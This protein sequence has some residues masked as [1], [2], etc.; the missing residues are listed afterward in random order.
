MRI[1]SWNIASIRKFKNY[2]YLE[3]NYDVIAI[4]EIRYNNL[5]DLKN[6]YTLNDYY[7]YWSISK[8]PGYSG[9]GIY[10]KQEPLDVLIDDD[11]RYIILY[12]KNF[13]I[14]NVYV[15][16]SG[17]TLQRLNERIKWDEMFKNLLFNISYQTNKKLILIGDMNCARC[18]IDVKNPKNKLNKPGFSI[19]E[20]ESFEKL[21]T[22][23]NLVDSY[24]HLHPNTIKYSYFSYRNR[25]KKTHSGWRLDYILISKELISNL[26]FADIDEDVDGSDH[27]PITCE[28]NIFFK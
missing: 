8:T 21:L 27:V 14:V 13:F 12:Y 11:G 1:V 23:L 16:N 4:Q 19:E 20:R 28:I 26:I 5:K 15:M 17:E 7:D 6:N 18:E 9:C 2:T 25:S 3:N 10:V 22:K 24:R